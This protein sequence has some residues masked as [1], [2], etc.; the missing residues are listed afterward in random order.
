MHV[1][2]EHARWARDED[3]AA[4]GDDHRAGAQG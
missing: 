2:D 4:F 3:A 1:E